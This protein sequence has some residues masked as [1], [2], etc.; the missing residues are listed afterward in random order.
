MARYNLPETALRAPRSGREMPSPP[1]P[2]PSPK[3]V[4][5]SGSWPL[6]LSNQYMRQRVRAHVKDDCR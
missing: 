5:A 6:P 3:P 1:P 4:H 2:C